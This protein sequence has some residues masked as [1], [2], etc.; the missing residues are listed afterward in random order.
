MLHEPAHR[1]A[2]V[3]TSFYA[4]DGLLGKLPRRLTLFYLWARARVV[5]RLFSAGLVAWFLLLAYNGGLL[6]QILSPVVSVGPNSNGTATLPAGKLTSLLTPPEL[7]A[8]PPPAAAAAV[9]AE[10]DLSRLRHLPTG[11]HRLSAFH[12]LSLL[13]VYNVTARGGYVT[14]LPPICL[15]LAVPPREALE[16][17][18][19]RDADVSS[20]VVDRIAETLGQLDIAGTGAVGHV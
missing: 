20:R 4:T 16:T 6:Q 12:W 1:P 10:D 11:R 5:Q 7:A 2:S 17:R 13:R 3:V 19:P 14:V 9:G 8:S 18:H 15:S